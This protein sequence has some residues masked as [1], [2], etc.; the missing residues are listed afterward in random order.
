MQHNPKET[1]TPP[2]RIEPTGFFTGVQIRPVIIGVVVD[3]IAT[4]FAMAAF[5]VGYLAKEL[6][7]KGEM[8][9]EAV[10]KYMETPEG[11]AVM[12]IIA[13]GLLRRNIV[14][15]GLAGLL[16]IGMVADFRFEP[17][18]DV[19]WDEHH[20]CIGSPEPCEVPAYPARY[21]IYWPG[22]DGT[23]TIRH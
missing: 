7:K 5:I 11:L 18:P 6:S 1:R 12:L 9:E 13:V 21:R 19:N 8:T 10:A 14:A 3:Y 2:P 4:Q 23:Y 20:T 15:M 22:A 16:A 17:H